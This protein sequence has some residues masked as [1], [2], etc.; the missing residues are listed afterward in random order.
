MVSDFFQDHLL[1]T[2]MS[3]CHANEK[4]SLQRLLRHRQSGG[5]F[6]DVPQMCLLSPSLEPGSVIDFPGLLGKQVARE[7]LYEVPYQNSADTLLLII[8]H[9]KFSWGC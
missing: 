5:S 1:R 8:F 3:Q 7:I 9:Y 6:L 4:V 2:S